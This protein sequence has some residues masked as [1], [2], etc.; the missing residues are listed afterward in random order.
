MSPIAASSDKPGQMTILLY[1][2]PQF[3]I[4]YVTLAIVNYT[5]AFYASEMG[6]PVLT[7][8]GLMLLSRG[9]DVVTDPLIGIL[10]DRTH[11]RLGRRKPWILA[12]TPVLLLGSWLLFLPG[13]EVGPIYF[14]AAI[15]LLFFGLTMVQL[16]YIAWGAELSFNYDVRTQIT[17][18]R[19]RVG[20]TGSIAA[21]ITAFAVSL[22]GFEHLRPVLGV[23]AWIIFLLLPPL[24]LSVVLRVPSGISHQGEHPPFLQGAV[25][26][27]RNRSFRLLAFTVFL[28]YIGIAPGG[29]IGW[30]LFDNY[31]AEPGLFAPSVLLEFIASFLGLPLWTALSLKTSK[32]R[33]ISLALLWMAVFTAL[34]P[35]AALLGVWGIMATVA[36]RSFA[37]GALLMLPMAI[38]A[39]VIDI[40]TAE[41][42]SQRTGIYIAFSGIVVKLAITIGVSTALAIPGLFGFDAS[43]ADNS[44]VALFSVL[45]TYSWMPALFFVAAAPLFWR[46]PLGRDEVAAAQARID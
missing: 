16:P 30:F 12:G 40:D 18:L 39:D 24:I 21:L 27:F 23:M 17:S 5:P 7:I 34:I 14:L 20:A 38:I 26:V 35:L 42:G 37:L 41:T 4:A 19:E 33:A 11:S 46:F 36:I 9:L 22:L 6:I 44:K 31:F 8:S 13:D 25:T 2:L 3:A 10:S 28:L 45:A 43:A 32:H 1:A 15:S 29:A